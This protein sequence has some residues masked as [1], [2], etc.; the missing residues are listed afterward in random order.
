MSKYHSVKTT[1]DG[2][3]FA[4]KREGNRYCELRLLAKAGLIRDLE[5]QPEF[6]LEINGEP[7]RYNE[8]KRQIRYIADFSYTDVKT[9]QRVV[10]DAK[11]M[12]L[13]ESKIKRAILAATTGIK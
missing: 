1:I 4:S 5:L 8:S 3:V 9:G 7:L 13:P 2:V 12:D 11:G 10:L 6:P